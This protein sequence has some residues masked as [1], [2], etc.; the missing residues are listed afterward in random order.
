MN[1]YNACLNTHQLLELD[2]HNAC[3]PLSF[4]KLKIRCVYIDDVMYTYIILN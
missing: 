3:V 4:T 1:I 2:Q